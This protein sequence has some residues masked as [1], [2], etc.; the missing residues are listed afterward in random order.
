MK[1]NY[2]TLGEGEP[3]IILHGLF[4]M[5]DNWQSFGKNLAS[6]YTVFLLDQ[7]N[8][9][10][11]PHDETFDYKVMAEDLREFMEENWIYKSRIIGHS[12]GGKTAMQFALEYPD[13]CEQLV[14]VDIG[15]KAYN[16]GHE[17]IFSALRSINLDNKS[18]RKEV[19]GDLSKTIDSYGVR[20]FLMKN[21]RRSKHSGSYEWKMALDYI[22]NNYQQILGNIPSQGSFDNPSLFVKGNESDYLSIGDMELIRSSFSN[23]NLKVINDA[24][25]W[26]HV[27]KPVELYTSIV[28]FFRS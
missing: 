25:H 6:D 21:L 17:S 27:D 10:K 5:L 2:K 28:N 24:G 20:Q 16:G 1:L 7:R 22:Y 9:G 8:H 3:V 15:P 4:G 11:S 23:S 14:V 19:E 12:M 26:V 18:S 13:M